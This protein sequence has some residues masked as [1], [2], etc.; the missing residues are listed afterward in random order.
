MDQWSLFLGVPWLLSVQT[1]IGTDWKKHGCHASRRGPPVLSCPSHFL[2]TTMSI[3][4][5]FDITAQA[6]E[7]GPQDTVAVRFE[8]PSNAANQML[9]AVK[10]DAVLHHLAT[11][12]FF[13]YVLV[14]AK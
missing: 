2:S 8:P 14:F 7:K 13:R 10:S 3:E 9:C 5:S 6:G 12:P 11:L 4:H 1:V